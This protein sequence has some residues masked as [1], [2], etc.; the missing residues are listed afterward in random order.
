MKAAAICLLS[1][2]VA[3]CSSYDEDLTEAYDAIVEN[4]RSPIVLQIEVS[5][6][7]N[8]VIVR[9]DDMPS[10]GVQSRK[11]NIND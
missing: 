8:G 2:S 11:E 10:L 4:C 5:T 9:C 7:S 3:G 1:L 6:Y